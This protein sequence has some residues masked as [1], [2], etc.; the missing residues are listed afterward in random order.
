[1]ILNSLRRAFTLIELLVVIAIIAILAAIL[2]PVFAQAKEAAKD[3]ANL[4]NHKQIGLAIL[5]YG[6]DYDD[7]FP[8]VQRREPTN[9]AIFGISTWQTE[10]QPYIKNWDIMFHTKNNRGNPAFKNWQQMLNYGAVPRVANQN[11]T[12][13]G[14]RDWMENTTAL[15]SFSRRVCN[16]QACRYTGLMG[17]GCE[18]GS[19]TG[20]GFA[21]P[22]TTVSNAPTPSLSQ[23]SVDQVASTILAAEGGMWDLW[24]GGFGLDGILTYG[25]IW[26]P[27]DYQVQGLTTNVMAGPH[28]RKAPKPQSPDGACTPSLCSGMS[29]GIV[30]GINTSVYADGHAKST[31]YR[32]GAMKI[33]QLGSGVWVI[34][35]MWPQGGF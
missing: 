5:M 11:L 33:A 20:T 8:L 7:F 30:N 28:G 27:S 22:A 9:T 14:P 29:F 4:S 34:T 32:G 12:A 19:C 10:C 25:G 13:F 26:S 18:G 35:S 6:A 17:I 2:F 1:L 15:G 24:M 21:Y 16:S 31:N 3:S 23:T